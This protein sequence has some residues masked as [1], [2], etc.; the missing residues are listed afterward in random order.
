MSPAGGSSS[1]SSSSLGVS[2]YSMWAG[3]G[4]GVAFCV[5]CSF[6][7]GTVLFMRS[8]TNAEAASRNN[9]DAAIDASRTVYP[10]GVNRQISGESQ[11]NTGRRSAGRLSFDAN[12]ELVF[13]AN[14][15][16][17]EYDESVSSPMYGDNSRMSQLFIAGPRDS[18]MGRM[19]SVRMRDSVTKLNDDIEE[20]MI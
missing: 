2:S 15:E 6:G 4:L 17:P 20:Q 10:E 3:I 9:S 11:M 18:G 19:S 8:K 16:E 13:K 5:L 7:I 12:D 14:E 1:S